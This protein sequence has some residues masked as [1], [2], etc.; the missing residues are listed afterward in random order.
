MD[1]HDCLFVRVLSSLDRPSYRVA[2]LDR[3]RLQRCPC[4]PGQDARSKVLHGSAHDS[5][6]DLLATGADSVP[7]CDSAQVAR[8]TSVDWA[9]IHSLGCSVFCFR[10]HFHLSKEIPSRWRLQYGRGISN[11]RFDLW[12]DCSD[13]CDLCASQGL[14]SSS[15]LGH[16]SISQILSPMLYRYFY[17]LVGSFEVYGY[18]GD[19]DCDSND[20]CLPFTRP[21]DAIHAWTYFMV[22]LAFAQAIV[23]FLPNDEE[24]SNNNNK[25][26]E[27][28]TER[29]DT[30]DS[31]FNYARFNM[32]GLFGAAF[33]VVSTLLIYVTAFGGTND[34]ST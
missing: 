16:S 10:H 5:W 15:K 28:P 20:V 23:W 6:G 18:K 9:S 7:A 1:R 19:L 33:A 8:S 34:I 27:N 29:S 2:L 24:A 31:P 30:T 13:D 11:F 14:D 21:F 32:L 3:A 17:L 25:D 26:E 12:G 22:P 4:R